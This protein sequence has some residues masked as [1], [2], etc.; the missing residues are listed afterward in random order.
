MAGNCSF[1]TQIH[2]LKNASTLYKALQTTDY[3]IFI[4]FSINGMVYKEFSKFVCNSTEI[5]SQF[6]E[7]SVLYKLKTQF[8]HRIAILYTV[9]N[10]KA[11]KTR[12]ISPS[13][14]DV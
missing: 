3:N 10:L 12:F 9:K 7:I 8:D 6:S 13:P 4:L 2:S 5:N 1:N 14:G 11:F